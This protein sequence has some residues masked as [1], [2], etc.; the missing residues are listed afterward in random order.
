MRIHAHVLTAATAVAAVVVFATTLAAPAALAGT[1]VD[2]KT[3]TPGTDLTRV[4][5][6][7]RERMA[8]TKTPG[9]AYAVVT[10]D[11]IEH[12]GTWG[13]G[14]NGNPVTADTP[15]L[16]GSVSKPVT[17]T[18]VMTLVESGTID[19]DE[20]VRSYLPSFTLAEDDAA[21][22]ISV[23]QLLEQTSGIP[24]GTGITD[25][26]DRRSD[27][28]NDAVADLVDATPRFSPGQRHE[29]TSANYLVLGAVVEAVTGQAF[30]E[31]LRERVLDPLQMTGVI[32]SPEEADV[33]LPEG[34]GYAFGQPVRVASHHDQTGPSYGYLG[35]TVEDLAH[36]AIAQLNNGRYRSTHVLQPASLRLISLWSLDVGWL[37]IAVV[38]A[39]LLLAATRLAT[40]FIRLTLSGPE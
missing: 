24:E 29:Y 16:W 11:S 35:G 17:A 33:A 6:Y 27:P 4:G 10:P 19:L 2:A 34:H 7:L 40:G 39:S 22:Q 1:T 30:D 18:A 15:F 31:Y 5:A 23:R 3:A 28:Y 20:P 32:A 14:G 8:A 26:F 36:F 21:A 12:T 13:E 37:L 9:L 38:A 25:R